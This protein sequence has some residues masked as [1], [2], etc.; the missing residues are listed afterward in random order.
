M[1]R[2]NWSS[3]KIKATSALTECRLCD[4]RHPL[5]FCREFRNANVEEKLRLVALHRYC[6]NCL[7]PLHLSRSCSSDMRCRYCGEN[8][9]SM[10]HGD[11]PGR[12]SSAALVREA[13][14]DQSGPRP[15]PSEPARSRRSHQVRTQ[16]RSSDESTDG[17]RP[18]PS[19]PSSEGVLR[20]CP[21]EP[22]REDGLR[23]SPSE[24]SALQIERLPPNRLFRPPLRSG[25]RPRPS[26]PERRDRRNELRDVRT[27]LSMAPAPMLMQRMVVLAP[28]AVVQIRSGGRRFR[29][30]A[31][32]D[33][34]RT[35]S[36]ISTAL[37]YRL[38]LEVA[39]IGAMRTCF[40]TLRGRNDSVEV[41]A[42]VERAFR[43]KTPEHS[44]DS[45]I[46]YEYENIFLADPD[47]YRAADVEIVLGIDVYGRILRPGVL[48]AAV[49]KPVAQNT[50]FGWVLS[51][52]C[53]M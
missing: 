43:R 18:R 47:F 35:M 36:V 39:Q 21:S 25:L 31:L 30:R 5:R 52:A 20:P 23:P 28:T 7:S 24:P 48:P 51:G 40:L 41:H 50:I 3:Q 29:I 16:D 15:S 4:G 6:A 53:P 44:L 22:P 45:R 34:G 26:R 10:L 14:S 13:A 12:V 11:H 42:R 49:N 2:F 27:R 46:A 17:L 32:I 9:H 1:G 19:E 37:I 8:H 38:R 33:A